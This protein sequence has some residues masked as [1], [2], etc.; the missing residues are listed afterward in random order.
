MLR[1]VSNDLV[2]ATKLIGI[3]DIDYIHTKN[4]L[5][6]EMLAPLYMRAGV[7]PEDIPADM[8]YGP[9]PLPDISERLQVMLEDYIPTDTLR[10]L[11]A[12]IDL[13]TDTKPRIFY[14]ADLSMMRFYHGDKLVIEIDKQEI[15][16]HL[17]RNG[18]EGIT[19][20]IEVLNSQAQL[21]SICEFIDF[22]KLAEKRQQK[23]LSNVS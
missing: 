5:V 12:T 8:K 2:L 17:W 18:E 11:C 15:S 22:Y 3:F 6:E 21:E 4:I 7:D 13:L 9:I 20:D 14:L 1:I 23:E 10:F 19:E 16:C